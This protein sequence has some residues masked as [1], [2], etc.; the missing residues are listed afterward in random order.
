MTKVKE[1]TLVC[2]TKVRDEIVGVRMHNGEMK[3]VLKRTV[4]SVPP[5]DRV[6]LF[7]KLK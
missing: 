5:V 6:E 1:Y 7:I 2:G 3:H 4:W